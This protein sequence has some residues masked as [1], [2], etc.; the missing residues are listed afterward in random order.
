MPYKP[1][2]MRNPAGGETNG[3]HNKN[4]QIFYHPNHHTVNESKRLQESLESLELFNKAVLDN[5]IVR[6]LQKYVGAI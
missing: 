1:P 4:A 5:L 2:E 3:V 6:A